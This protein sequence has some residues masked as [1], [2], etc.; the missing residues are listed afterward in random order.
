MPPRPPPRRPRAALPNRY[1]LL[2]G[3]N[4][5]LVQDNV[6]GLIWMS[7]SV[8]GGER[9]GEGGPQTEEDAA[10]YC[11]DRGMRLPTED[12][13]LALAATNMP[14]ITTPPPSQCLCGNSK[15]PFG[16][17]STWTSTFVG[18]DSEAWVVDYTG[19]ATFNLAD[20]FPSS[21]LCV[22]GSPG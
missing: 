9:V 14:C 18:G 15:L 3:T 13:A 20:N 17:W 12:E 6:T 16:F 5:G 7:D 2:T 1:T 8:G 10:A 21:V 11:Q 4:A 22:R 19:T